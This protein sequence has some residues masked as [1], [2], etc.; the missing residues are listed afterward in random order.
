MESRDAR[1]TNERLESRNEILEV[2]MESVGFSSRH[3][4]ERRRSE[5]GILESQIRN[6]NNDLPH[7]S[8]DL[9]FVGEKRFPTQSFLL[10]GNNGKE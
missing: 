3:P 10:L 6:F 1:K 9:V 8:N 4:R 5:S 2:E 7:Q